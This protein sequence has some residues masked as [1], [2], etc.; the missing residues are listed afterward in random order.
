MKLKTIKDY[1]L[2]NK[3]VIIRLD[4]NV[5]ME[6]GQITDDTKIK[7]SLATIEYA[8][9]HN[10]KVI[11][12]S[13]L[14]RVKEEKDKLT[15]SLEPVSKKLSKL[16]NKEVK[17]SKE[18]SGANLK[19]MVDNM[20]NGEILLI[21]N[22]RFEDI[23]NKTESSCNLELSKYWASLGDIFINDAYGSAHRAHASNVGIANLLPNGIGFL[24]EKELTKLKT[25]LEEDTHPYIVIMG[26]KKVEDKIKIIENLIT[27]C[28][29]LIIG[30][31]MSYTFLK[32][33]GYNVENNIIDENSIDFCH[34]ML[35]KYKDKI[36]LPI[37][38]TTETG[39]NIS[40]ENLNGQI[41]FDIGIKSQELF[42]ETLSNAKRVIINGPLGMFEKKP[43][44]QGTKSIYQF[45]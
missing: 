20:N 27:K 18:T 25:F 45:L 44:D 29:K 22:T 4:L 19:N 13:H 40:L 35:N 26:G 15:S 3:R 9:Q 37:D 8:Y 28:D 34:S 12:M 16:L 30:G 11:L 10:A 42:K 5:P 38:V 2:N 1:D 39:Q 43:F 36:V 21:E 14:G 31:A 24:V 32:V 23:D 33:K 6:N 17:F 7:E 41:G